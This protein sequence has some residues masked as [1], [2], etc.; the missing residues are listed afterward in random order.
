METEWKRMLGAESGSEMLEKA[1]K[2][3][4][5]GAESGGFSAGIRRFS[6]P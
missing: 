2:P 1:D 3:A 5:D 4:Q 6:W